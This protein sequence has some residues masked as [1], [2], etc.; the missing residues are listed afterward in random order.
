MIRSKTM[1]LST[2][3]LFAFG[4]ARDFCA[5][6]P[7]TNSL[8]CCGSFSEP[9]VWYGFAPN[10]TTLFSS[11]CC[12]CPFSCSS[13]CAFTLTSPKIAPSNSFLAS[14]SN[15]NGCASSISSSSSSLPP[16]VLYPIP[17]SSSIS[18]AF[19]CNAALASGFVLI[20]SPSS[21]L[22]TASYKSAPSSPSA[23]ANSLS[24]AAL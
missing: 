10:N 14:S 20:P 4:P 7:N 2:L 17:N 6:F 19:P 21:L 11:C 15:G 24:S 9:G 5:V 16:P 1:T 23:T 13:L 18:A 8:A 3:R 12:S 22:Y